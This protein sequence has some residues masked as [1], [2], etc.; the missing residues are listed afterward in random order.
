MFLTELH[1]MI[2]AIL[3]FHA[4]CEYMVVI[5]LLGNNPAQFVS[6]RLRGPH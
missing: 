6:Q 3:H 5:N 4:I 2:E 1:N